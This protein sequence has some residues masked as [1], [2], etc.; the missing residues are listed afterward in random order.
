VESSILK[1][2]RMNVSMPVIFVSTEIALLIKD[3]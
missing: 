1:E 3:A 2:E